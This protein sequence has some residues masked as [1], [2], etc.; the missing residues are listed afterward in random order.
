MLHLQVAQAQQYL[1]HLLLLVL[2][3]LVAH[4]LLVLT[5][6]HPLQQALC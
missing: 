3:L 1:L 6:G 4:H 5:L 2:L